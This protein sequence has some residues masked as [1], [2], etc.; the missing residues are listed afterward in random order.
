MVDA[1]D[2]IAIAP[3]PY[4]AAGRPQF[5]FGASTMSADLLQGIARLGHRAARGRPPVGSRAA[6]GDRAR[7]Q[8]G[9][10]G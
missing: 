3:L 4:R 7:R 8:S 9:G 6:P 1:M 10:A 5:E 2:V